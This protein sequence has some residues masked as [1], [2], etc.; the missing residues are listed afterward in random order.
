MVVVYP[1]DY[2]SWCEHDKDL[3]RGDPCDRRRGV[4]AQLIPLV[5]ALE[6]TETVEPSE[7]AE[8]ATEAAK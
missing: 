4:F 7:R 2:W 3:E 5:V 1:T 6:D 8:E